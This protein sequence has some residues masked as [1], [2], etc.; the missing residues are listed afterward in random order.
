MAI[1]RTWT[2]EVDQRDDWLSAAK[3]F[4][5][6][7]GEFAG[8]DFTVLWPTTGTANVRIVSVRFDNWA[9]VDLWNDWQETRDGKE[10]VIELSRFG[11][12]VDRRPFEVL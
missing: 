4:G 5:Q 6:L 3:K 12:V 11:S 10:A 2:W 7:T 9:S 1:I 8:K